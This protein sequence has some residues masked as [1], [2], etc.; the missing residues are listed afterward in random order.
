MIACGGLPPSSPAAIST[1]SGS[2]N[3]HDWWLHSDRI[4]LQPHWQT[5]CS[6]TALSPAARSSPD[7]AGAAVGD[8]TAAGGGGDAVPGTAGVAADP[9]WAEA[10][11]GSVGGVSAAAPGVTA[12]SAAAASD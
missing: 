11:V 7:R 2:A 12:R 3:G 6:E 4:M 1:R 8:A 9:A 5:S 10:G